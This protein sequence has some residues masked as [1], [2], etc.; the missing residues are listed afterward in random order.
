MLASFRAA[1]A[2]RILSISGLLA[3]CPI[4]GFGAPVQTP[5]VRQVADAD[6]DFG[7][8]LLAQL[9][10]EKPDGNI[11]FSPYSI[12]HCLSLVLNGAG[13]T[14]RSDLMTT[15]GLKSLT[16]DQINQANHKLLV[17][18]TPDPEVQLLAA[19]ALWANKGI[20]FDPAFEQRCTS[21]YGARTS[22]LDFDAPA[23]ADTINQWVKENTQGKIDKFVSRN[24]LKNSDILLT[25][26]VYFHGQWTQ[27]FNP[28]YTKPGSFMLGSGKS[29]TVPMMLQYGSYA[30]L[31][32]ADFQAV[33]L[34]Y[35]KGDTSMDIF[36]PKP[37]NDLT[38]FLN[39]LNGT[40]WD[41]WIN[42]MQSTGIEV[43]LP[44]FHAD[45]G[46]TLNA[47]LTALGMGSAFSRGA[48]F[49]PMGIPG[50]S[51]SKV[52]H[53]ATLDVDEKGATGSAVTGVYFPRG[54]TI[55]VIRID[56]PFFVAIRDNTTGAVLFAGVIREPE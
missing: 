15:L 18:E 28:D 54:G 56:H 43:D 5:P 53:K 30:Y 29:K 50:M 34:P 23:A 48:D 24:D 12:S 40:S 32:T 27:P 20:R 6:T 7:F 38:G 16:L 8:R 22:T 49:T 4:S 10:Q 19:N 3:F 51:I 21:F 41:H 36:L 44:R 14:T 47:P 52:I 13:G 9:N 25:N 11:V 55:R 37:G 39:G 26:A 46:T 2:L 35:G 42:S 33:S 31:E 45:F 1:R 17:H